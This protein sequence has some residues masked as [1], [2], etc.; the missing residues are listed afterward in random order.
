V[1]DVQAFKTDLQSSFNGRMQKTDP[2]GFR[3]ARR[4]PPAMQNLLPKFELVPIIMYLMLTEV[5]AAFTH[6]L[7]GGLAGKRRIRAD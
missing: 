7:R 3:K 1:A 2:R 5:P 6:A 4:A